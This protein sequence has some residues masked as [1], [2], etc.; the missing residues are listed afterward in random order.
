[1]VNFEPG[2]IANTNHPRINEE[3]LPA[4]QQEVGSKSTTGPRTQPGKR[5][6]KMNAIKHGIF[7]AGI[8][9]GFERKSDHEK[10]FEDLCNYFQPQNVIDELLVEKLAMLYRRHRR[11]LMA[12]AAEILKQLS[13]DKLQK[14]ALEQE[15]RLNSKKSE[16]G[17]MEFLANPFVVV[18]CIQLLTYWRERICHRGY[19]AYFDLP[20]MRKLYGRCPGE[21]L[22]AQTQQRI[23]EAFTESEW[24]THK[25]RSEKETHEFHERQCKDLLSKL[26]GDIEYLKHVKSVT[27]SVS[28]ELT[29]NERN[30]QLVP[31]AENLDRLIRYEAHICREV[32]RTL[33]HLEQSIRMRLGQPVPPSINIEIGQ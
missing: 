26:D 9:S 27:D 22:D 21:E 1:M 12:E 16:R 28:T 6:S 18:R 15:D 20:L 11:L 19:D 7:A 32:D 30:S 8:L 3:L 5:R 29:E 4:S 24:N 31:R 17:L 33:G 2:R 13:D 14:E 23:T 10:L 25:G